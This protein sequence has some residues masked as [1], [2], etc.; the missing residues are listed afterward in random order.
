MCLARALWLRLRLKTPELTV[1]GILFLE[2]LP[3]GPQEL[4]FLFLST[5]SKAFVSFHCWF[6]VGETALWFRMVSTSGK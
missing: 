6:K 4:P 2:R 1:R 3:E 5:V